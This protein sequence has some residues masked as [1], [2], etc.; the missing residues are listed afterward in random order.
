MLGDLGVL[1]GVTV[2][3]AV[4]S[5]ALPP[6]IFVF[7]AFVSSGFSVAISLEMFVLS[8]ASAFVPFVA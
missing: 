8:V 2:V 4:F 1:C 5:V 3:I 7:C 6:A